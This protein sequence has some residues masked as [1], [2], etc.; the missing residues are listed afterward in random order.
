MNQVITIEG[1]LFYLKGRLV[2][3]SEKKKVFDKGKN[4]IEN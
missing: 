4:E 2:V 1:V 3:F